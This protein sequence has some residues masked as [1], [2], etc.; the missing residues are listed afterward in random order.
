MRPMLDNPKRPPGP[1]TLTRFFDTREY[2][3]DLTDFP[4][5]VPQL[6][7]LMNTNLTTRAGEVATRIA[8]AA[9][10]DKARV[11]EDLYLT[12]LARRPKPAELERMLAYVEKQGN[13]QRGYAGVMWALLNSAEFVSNH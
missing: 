4:F 8:K 2:D 10:S 1:V 7:K 12:A 3:D 11:I 5:G 9:G 13:P 6:L